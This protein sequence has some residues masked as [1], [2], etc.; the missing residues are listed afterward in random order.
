MSD[1]WLVSHFVVWGLLLVM[2]VVVMSLMRN[3]GRLYQMLDQSTSSSAGS[4]LLVNAPLPSATVRTLAGEAIATET[5]GGSA[6]AFV[7]VSPHCGPCL[8]ALDELAAS[9][10]Q[11]DPFDLGVEQT[12]LI[13][14]GEREQIAMVL[15][16]HGIA[17]DSMPI[18]FDNNGS[19]AAA[20]GIQATPTF[21]TVDTHQHVIVQRSGFAP[22]SLSSPAAA[23]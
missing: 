3:M 22:R 16:D 15:Q 12:V 13:S 9:P 10:D 19:L 11:A 21:I 7:V 14:V 8:D 2:G 20:W 23:H 5:L 1:F 6:T 17:D 4:L 18:F